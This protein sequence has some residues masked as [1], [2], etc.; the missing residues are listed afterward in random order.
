MSNA[1]NPQNAVYAILADSVYWDVRYGINPKTGMLDSLNSNWTPVPQ[2]WK[3]I[4]QVSKSGNAWYQSNAFTAR[5]YKNG[6]EIV[7]AIAGTNPKDFVGD[8]GANNALFTGLIQGK[9]GY[10]LQAAVF[11]HEIKHKYPNAD[12]KFTGQ[13]RWWSCWNNGDI[14]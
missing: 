6:N 2:G 12:I 8:M 14:V 9:N 11:Y 1:I 10:A 7:I 3:L 4:Q 13:S 5:A